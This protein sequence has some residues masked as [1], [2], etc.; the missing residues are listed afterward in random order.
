MTG[1]NDRQDQSLTGQVRDQAGHCPLTVRYFQ[2]WVRIKSWIVQGSSSTRVT[3]LPG[4]SFLHINGGYFNFRFH[5][6]ESIISLQH[7]IPYRLLIRIF[8]FFGRKKT[9]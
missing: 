8:Y 7:Q 1:Q 6:Q 3:L 4:T 5:T 9:P 2:P